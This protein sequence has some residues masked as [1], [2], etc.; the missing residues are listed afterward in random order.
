MEFDAWSVPKVDNLQYARMRAKLKINPFNFDLKERP[1][2][3]KRGLIIGHNNFDGWL[4]LASNG[5]RVSLVS[6]FMPSGIP[7]LGTLCILQQMAYYQKI[8]NAEL[9]IPIADIEA[10]CVRNKSDKDIRE[11]TPKLIAHL[12]AAGVNIRNSKIYLQSR[13]IQTLKIALNLASFINKS[14]FEGLYGRKLNKGE[15]ISSLAMAAD[16]IYPESFKYDGILVT[17]GIDE[18][19]HAKL[20]YEIIKK[21][22]FKNLISFTYCNLLQGILGSKMGKSVPQN[23]IKLDDGSMYIQNFIENRVSKKDMGS[24][25][26]SIY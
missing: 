21:R 18:I 24:N 13:N 14:K 8:Y 25:L 7:H 4:E 16:I 23:S 15:I 9:F 19:S 5:K 11:I 1:N 3:S 6:G 12:M 10:T 17:L 2:F 22:G 26:Q 20:V